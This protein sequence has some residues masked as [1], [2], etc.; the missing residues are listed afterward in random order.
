MLQ[1]WKYQG[2]END[3]ILIDARD[4]GELIT[5]DQARFL[6]LR[7][8]GIGA[9]GVL[10]LLPSN[11]AEARMHIYNAD[12]SVPQ[13]CGN[14]IRCLVKHLVERGEVAG[15][16][17]KIETGRGVLTC[18]A[19]RGPHRTVDSVTVDM[20]RPEFERQ[21]IPM[22]GEGPT[23]D[24]PLQV[25]GR[26]VRVTA[27]ALGNPHV[28]LFDRPALVRELGAALESHAAFPERVNVSF[29]KVRNRTEIDL[30]VYERGAGL[31]AACGTG[32]CAT[33]VAAVLWDRVD[34][35]SPIKV[36]QAGGTLEIRV[37]RDFRTVWMR[38]PAVLVYSGKVEGAIPSHGL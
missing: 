38:G 15:P 31:T 23:R 5:P 20:G 28:V 29:A 34:A 9:D 35:E 8:V 30:A 26:E 37:E 13:M 21:R 32:A 11:A 27:L 2:L 16:E 36:N 25:L 1:F 19:H 10:T 33:A 6:C 4:G 24:V 17:V 7:Q 14:G 3:F 22:T 18:I 12:G